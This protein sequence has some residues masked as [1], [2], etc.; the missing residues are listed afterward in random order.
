MVKWFSIVLF[1]VPGFLAGQILQFEQPRKLSTAVNSEYEESMPLLSPDRKTLFFTRL[2]SP[3]NKGGQYSGT[4]VWISRYDVT[5]I[6][7]SNADNSHFE[8]TSGNNTVIGVSAKGD[9]V[10]VQNTTASR[11]VNGIYFSKKSGNTWTDPE[12]IPLKGIP[13]EGFLGLY[14]SPDL[15]VIFLSMK[16]VDSRGEE[17]LYISIKNPAGDWAEP[18]NLGP[19]INTRGFE[20]SPYLSTDKKRLYFASNGHPGQGDADIFVSERQYGSWEVWSPP[21]NL[22]KEVNSPKFDAYFSIY[23]DSLCFFASNRGGKMSDIYQSKIKVDDG[24]NNQL[25]VDSL[26]N[27]TKELLEQ[28]RTSTKTLTSLAESKTLIMFDDKVSRV[29]AA[30]ED[31]LETYADYL[32]KN[33]KTRLFVEYD[34]RAMNAT[35][36]LQTLTQDRIR[37]VRQIL[38]SYGVTENRIVVS[39]TMVSTQSDQVRRNSVQ[40]SIAK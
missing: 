10:F 22:G 8:N 18:K 3:K 37:R 14:V 9:R 24:K 40:L 30:S 2:L 27:Q 17:D 15:D 4:D 7:W 29:Q 21:K 33:V 36:A 34:G 12:L 13:S 32:M 26:V 25:K 23:G 19:T 35:P 16:G 1:C 6:D 28:L 31:A 39:S 38:K 20:I 5:K 11:D